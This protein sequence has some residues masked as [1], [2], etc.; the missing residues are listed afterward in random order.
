MDEM[1]TQ[2]LNAPKRQL[3]GRYTASCPYVRLVS[4]ILL[5]RGIPM[6]KDPKAVADLFRHELIPDEAESVDRIKAS[7]ASL[8]DISGGLS[9]SR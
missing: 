6:P 3:F 7:Q 1:L 4:W 9:T 8:L 5:R 2:R